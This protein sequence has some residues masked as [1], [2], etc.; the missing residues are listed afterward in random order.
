MMFITNKIDSIKKWFNDNQVII[1]ALYGRHFVIYVIASIL[2][3]VAE[4]SK[5]AVILELCSVLQLSD[6]F[7]TVVIHAVIGCAVEYVRIKFD[8][9]TSRLHKQF[10]HSVKEKLIDIIHEK[11]QTSPSSFL[12]SSGKIEVDKYYMDLPSSMI[13]ECTQKIQQCNTTFRRL[14]GC[15][16]N[17]WY[18]QAIDINFAIM[19][20]ALL[21]IDKCMNQWSTSMLHDTNGANR[22]I[23]LLFNISLINP[24]IDLNNINEITKKSLKSKDSFF[25]CNGDAF[26]IVSNIVSALL[27]GL[28]VYYSEKTGQIE[29]I[30][31]L[32]T[33]AQTTVD[34]GTEIFQSMKPK[35]KPKYCETYMS[36]DP[37]SVKSLV[38]NKNDTTK[39]PML[40]RLDS[41]DILITNL[42]HGIT[43]SNERNFAIYPE[44]EGQTLKVGEVYLI[45]GEN[46]AGKSTCIENLIAGRTTDHVYINNRPTS[47]YHPRQFA[48]IN[49]ITLCLNLPD[50]YE[51][52]MADYLLIF[53][54]GFG[55]TKWYK[56]CSKVQNFLNTYVPQTTVNYDLLY[57]IAHVCSCT[58]FLQ[59]MLELNS[60][61]N[62]K[63][64]N[65]SR[66]QLQKITLTIY[67]Y[68]MLM[69]KKENKFDTMIIGLDEVDS[70]MDF[71][72]ALQLYCRL[73]LL[74]K[75]HGIL[76][77]MISHH[78]NVHD[79]AAGFRF[80]VTHVNN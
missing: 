36:D 72:S 27:R 8:E 5:Y 32:T 43:E 80:N 41:E 39:K 65:G 44:L 1:N 71:N 73:K 45:T 22:M 64:L 56:K 38:K 63:V 9:M 47:S 57:E 55:E 2:L 50:S 58:D 15:V 11:V 3:Y 23:A 21:L 70:N 53:Q 12:A 14:S 28:V 33:V 51:F 78:S 13:N 60:E 68:H 67:L 79:V 48:L 29:A 52:T 74:A 59:N 77:F 37:C 69:G 42:V 31:I 54:K 4:M 26:I 61:G 24:K 17:L 10:E 25:G 76:F 7:Y 75:N 40:L 19:Y 49:H 16:R 34:Y 30:G 66:G 6:R 46:G 62:Y 18:M 35:M 20:T